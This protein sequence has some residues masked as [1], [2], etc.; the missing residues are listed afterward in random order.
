MARQTAA[1]GGRRRVA[2]VRDLR[3]GEGDD[4]LLAR[5]YVPRSR[6][7][8]QT[9]P[10][11]LFLHGGGFV[12]GGP[13]DAR[14]R[15][16][17]LAEEA[18]SGCWPWTT[19]SP[20]STP[21]G[22][23]RRRLGGVPL[24]ARATRARRRRPRPPGRRRGLG[25]R[26]PRGARRR[27]AAAEGLPL[28]FQMLVYPITDATRTGGSREAYAAGL[29]PHRRRAFIELAERSYTPAT[30]QPHPTRGCRRCWPP[31]TSPTGWRPR[32]SRRPGGTRCATRARTT[33]SRCSAPA[34]G[35]RSAA[36]QPVPR[37]PQHRRR[38]A[39]LA[40]RRAGGRGGAEG[41]AGL[42]RPDAQAEGSSRPGCAGGGARVGRM[43]S[44]I[45]CGRSRRR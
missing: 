3:L 18:A 44:P 35:S 36:T 10:T 28:A 33:A 20:P 5:L 23:A 40:P 45:P 38:R 24:D 4:A 6:L 31:T 34:S 19:A 8:E 37:L 42:T 16:R 22:R 43:R 15:C 25:R 12:F 41:G 21:S 17:F 11:L 14:R 26:E 7:L 1:A 39:D 27:R 2:S 32:T 13:R 30:G 29:L 9:A